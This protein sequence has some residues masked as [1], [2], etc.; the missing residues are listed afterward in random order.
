MKLTE[1][2]TTELLPTVVKPVTTQQTEDLKNLLES[3][4]TKS[5]GIPKLS[6]LCERALQTFILANRTDDDDELHGDEKYVV[7]VLTNDEE[8]DDVDS[9]EAEDYKDDNLECDINENFL[10]DSNFTK[11]LEMLS[12][13]NPLDDDN[14]FV[15]IDDDHDFEISHEEEVP[16]C[17]KQKQTEVQNKI[18]KKYLYAKY[19]QNVNTPVRYSN[20]ILRK[21]RNWRIQS[22]RGNN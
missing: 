13:T 22:N 2:E 7:I 12:N 19:V 11:F 21:Y 18:F 6:D 17:S 8:D 14:V 5:N 1:H 10:K 15:V 9:E 4:S 20:R 16:D 3:T